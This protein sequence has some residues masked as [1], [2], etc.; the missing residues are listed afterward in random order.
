MKIIINTIEIAKSFVDICSKYRD[1]NID[2]IQGRYIIDGKSI[3]G[4]LS[5]NLV[6][7][8]NVSVDSKNEETYIE[9]FRE[10][11]KWEVS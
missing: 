2:V 8:I 7:P 4:I 11:Q 1:F 5:L 10:I 9:F 3:L 6:E